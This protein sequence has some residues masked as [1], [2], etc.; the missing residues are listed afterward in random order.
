MRFTNVLKKS[1]GVMVLL[2]VLST[3]FV[4]NGEELEE[5]EM[6]NL[7]STFEYSITPEDAMWDEF[8]TV[9]D[10]IEACRI[11][12]NVLN[13]MTDEQLVQAVLD[14]PF[15]CD[16]FLYS[17]TEE[18]V[19]NLEEIC[20]AYAELL[21]RDNAKEI[22]MNSVNNRASLQTINLS[23]E[24]EVKNEA[25]AALIVYQEEL[26]DDLSVEEME[27][28]TKISTTIGFYF[29]ENNVSISSYTD[30]KVQ[31][32]KGT[33]VPYEIY[34]CNHS[35]SNYHIELDTMTAEA[36]GVTII[37][38][39]SCKYNCHS[40]AWHNQ[41]TS[42]Q[43]WINNPSLYMTDGS[44]TRITSGLGASG[45]DIVNG[46]KVFYGTE[47]NPTHSAI[48][49]SP[50]TGAALA[51]RTVKSKWGQCGVFSHTVADVPSGYDLNN[52]SV[53]HR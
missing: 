43:Y 11:P 17:S 27:E 6:E 35:A 39:G 49:A 7:T 31:T 18:G 8:G 37:S 38:Y 4:V 30:S 45:L 50:A 1:M 51:S 15:L 47:S 48:M 52:V 23:A 14:F 40:Y 3:G 24:E 22:L 25:L 21:R 10:K 44:Y 26:H 5:Q 19:Q 28:I 20:D 53:W 32:P 29:A 46:D 12:Q 36:Y 9:E 33:F 42:N 34:S 13:S 41:S 2:M 16:V